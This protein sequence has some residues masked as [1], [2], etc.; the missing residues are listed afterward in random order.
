MKTGPK[1]KENPRGGMG[2]KYRYAKAYAPP[3]GFPNDK[4]SIASKIKLF[5]YH[6]NGWWVKDR[7]YKEHLPKHWLIS[8]SDSDYKKRIKSYNLG[9]TAKKKNN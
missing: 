9:R 8:K 7:V 3:C 2:N 6:G 1:Q 5:Q 4:E